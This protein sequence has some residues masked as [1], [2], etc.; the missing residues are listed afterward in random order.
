VVVVAFVLVL[1]GA[2]LET[3]R[4]GSEDPAGPVDPLI[5]TD[6]NGHTFPGAAVPFGMVQFSPI[7]VAGG[8]GG[9]QY[10]ETRLS[11]FG[12]VFGTVT[13]TVVAERAQPSPRSDDVA[14][15]VE[16]PTDEKK[17][18]LARSQQSV[19]EAASATASAATARDDARGPETTD[20]VSTLFGPAG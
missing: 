17:V 19:T 7:S 8:P 2:P 14:R 4:A 18:A 13:P 3:A 16:I 10:S 9:Y 11:G 5:G 20:H 6:G 15:A 1:S 12:L